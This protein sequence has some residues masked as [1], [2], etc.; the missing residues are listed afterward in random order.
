M[1]RTYFFK[2]GL[3]HLLEGVAIKNWRE[4]AGTVKKGY[5]GSLWPS[6]IG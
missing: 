3:G 6:F 1:I 2:G 5:R 4:R